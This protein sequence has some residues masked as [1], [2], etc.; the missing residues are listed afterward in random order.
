MIPIEGE[1]VESASAKQCFGDV[2]MS[3]FREIE[4]S[5]EGEG[6]VWIHV[7]ANRTCPKSENQHREGSI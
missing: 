3:A 4:K 7:K 6:P 5:L 2:V 1:I